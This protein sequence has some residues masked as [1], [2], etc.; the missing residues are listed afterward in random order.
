MPGHSRPGQAL[1]SKGAIVSG[2]YPDCIYNDSRTGEHLPTVQGKRLADRNTTVAKASITEE[3]LES[4]TGQT[5][6]VRRDPERTQRE[7]LHVAVTEFSRHGFNGARIDEIARQ[8]RTSKRMIY[9]YFG[10]KQGLYV[11]ALRQAYQMVRQLELNLDL[12]SL[13]PVAALRE[14]VRSSLTY[15]ENNPDNVRIIA[16]EN[17]LLNGAMEHSDPGFF[18]L[19]RSA[20][21]VVES[22]LARGRASGV[23]RSGPDAPSALDVHQVLS[24]LALN[25][26]EHQKS[27]KAIFGRDML[28]PDAGPH[29][30]ELI[31][32]TVL[33]LVLADADQ[34]R[35]TS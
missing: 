12:D 20:V 7:I 25:R 9:Y 17:L 3:S 29:V 4:E 26:T 23:F 10:S 14:L 24:A 11:E 31:E 18:E 8:T 1:R 5:P 28:G 27:F 35:V 6:P 30:R 22:I 15:F 16:S 13:E 32:E 34:A 2:S 33:R 19:N 21:D